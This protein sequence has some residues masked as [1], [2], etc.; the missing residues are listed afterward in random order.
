[1]ADGHSSTTLQ[2]ADRLI[3]LGKM[4]WPHLM[5]RGLLAEQIYRAHSILTNHPYHRA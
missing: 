5:V 1:G 3:S 2:S 4:T